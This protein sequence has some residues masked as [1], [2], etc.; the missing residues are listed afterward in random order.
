M[1]YVY[2]VL[3]FQPCRILFSSRCPLPPPTPYPPPPQ[4]S[5][6]INKL[7]ALYPP[8]ICLWKERDRYRKYI[9]WQECYMTNGVWHKRPISPALGLKAIRKNSSGAP[10]KKS[11]E[12]S[13]S[14]WQWHVHE[15]WGIQTD[16]DSILNARNGKRNSNG[17][18]AKSLF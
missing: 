15:K 4:L 3:S 18:W 5:H 16:G 6:P 9:A 17:I 8:L 10:R 13:E 12:M 2:Y 14:E 1:Y 7:M 11:P